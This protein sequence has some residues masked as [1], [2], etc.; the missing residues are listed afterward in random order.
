MKCT[1]SQ[2]HSMCI[3]TCITQLPLVSGLCGMICYHGALAC[4]IFRFE[5]VHGVAFGLVCN[6]I[7][8]DAPILQCCDYF[9]LSI[10][11]LLLP[12]HGQV[13]QLK[14]VGFL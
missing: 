7:L 8:A 6:G 2:S 11:L 9:F 4:H 14:R 13:Q 10:Q 12:L 5:L 1:R 3:N